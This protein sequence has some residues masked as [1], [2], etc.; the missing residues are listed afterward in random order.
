MDAQFLVQRGFGVI[1]RCFL[2]LLAMLAGAGAGMAHAEPLPDKVI[3]QT[4]EQ[5]IAAL[6]ENREALATD[7]NRIYELID[8]IALP[9]FD[10]ET[11]VR[12]ILGKAWRKA[13]ADQRK[14]FSREFQ[15]FIMNIYAKQLVKYSDEELQIDPLKP[16]AL[17]SR[18]VT[19]H[20]Q[21]MSRATDP[22]SIDYRMHLSGGDWKICD[23]TVEGVSLVINYRNSFAAEIRKSGLDALIRKLAGH[24]ARFKLEGSGSPVP[25]GRSAGFQVVLTGAF[26]RKAQA[27]M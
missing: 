17:D 21:I 25:R 24:N 20:S 6:K 5:M 7:P 11:I 4:S 27:Y 14:R 3:A 19:V 10:I 12:Q 18:Y 22:I 8:H 9:H 16:E 23:F 2:L 26:S 15:T 1:N 13:S